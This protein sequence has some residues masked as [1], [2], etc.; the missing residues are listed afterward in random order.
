MI[1]QAHS[2][3][4]TLLNAPE[5]LPEADVLRP[6]DLPGEPLAGPP[7]VGFVL[8]APVQSLPALPAFLVFSLASGP[9][10]WTRSR[11]VS[12]LACLT[13]TPHSVQ[14][15][16]SLFIMWFLLVWV[17]HVMIWVLIAMAG[18]KVP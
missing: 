5:R 3:I 15:T 2:L 1:G 10:E 7:G 17:D 8:G 18:G 4:G 9:R 14:L 16:I 12:R 13:C 6:G 11:W